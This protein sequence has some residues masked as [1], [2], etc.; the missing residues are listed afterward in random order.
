[1][2]HAPRTAGHSGLIGRLLAGLAQQQEAYSLRVRCAALCIRAG[3]AGAQ[4]SYVMIL[5]SFL[6]ARRPPCL[7]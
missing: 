6:P 1:M 5:P 4:L 3:A 7:W 2:D